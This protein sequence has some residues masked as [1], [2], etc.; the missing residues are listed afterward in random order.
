MLKDALLILASFLGFGGGCMLLCL[1]A[2][3]LFF[4]AAGMGTWGKTILRRMVF[5]CIFC[6]LTSISVF[7]AFSIN[8]VVPKSSE[9]I[10]N[11]P[12]DPWP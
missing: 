12:S 11:Y 9:I 3:A 5:I 6:L 2:L 7:N 1:P 4:I 8:P 10:N